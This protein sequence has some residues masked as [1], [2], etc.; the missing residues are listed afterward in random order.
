MKKF[1]I[2]KILSLALATVI[3][4]SAFSINS[5]AMSD[6]AKEHKRDL[7]ADEVT[8]ISY[9]F[10]ADVYAKL[11]PDVVDALGDDETAL[12]TH[13]LTFGIWEQRQATDSFNVDVYAS[14]N[15]D[16]QKAF[17]DDIVSY[18]VHYAT[19]GIK[20]N[21]RAK[22]TL[23]DAYYARTT[24]YS[25]YDFVKGQTGAKEG[26]IPVQTANYAPNLDLLIKQ[27]Q[28]NGTI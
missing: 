27:I 23:A 10:K 26:A 17:G 2:T 25:V 19:V 18:Y 22:P 21:W 7:T 13:F 4:V 1:K 8:A 15:P 9:I 14:R 20:E 6:A 24:V 12:L 5:F 3:A 16:L 28:A 11:Y